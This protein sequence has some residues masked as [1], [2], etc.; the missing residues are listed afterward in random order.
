MT[1]AFVLSGGGSLGAVQVGM[2]RALADHGIEP[3]LLV[4]TS[5]GALNAAFVSGHGGGAQS[6]DALAEVWVGLHARALLT[7]DARQALRALAR[8]GRSLCSDRGLRALL[9]RHLPFIR[10][11]HAPIPLVVVATE[12]L[13]GREV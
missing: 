11:E 12:L 8:R 1:T 6:V 10:L 5:A 4:G 13:T 2:L 3:D 7:V 9:D